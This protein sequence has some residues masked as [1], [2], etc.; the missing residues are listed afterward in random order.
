MDILATTQHRLAA[1]FI[2][3]RS[4]YELGLVIQN[5]LLCYRIHMKTR[6]RKHAW[7]VHRPT[8]GRPVNLACLLP[9]TLGTNRFKSKIQKS[10]CKSHK[11]Y[12]VASS[13][14]S[15][16]NKTTMRPSM[17]LLAALFFR[18]ASPQSMHIKNPV[19]PPVDVTD[20]CLNVKY[21]TRCM[22]TFKNYAVH[23]NSCSPDW[24]Y[25]SSICKCVDPKESPERAC[26]SKAERYRL[27]ARIAQVETN[28]ARMGR[29]ATNC[30]LLN[31]KQVEP[32]TGLLLYPLPKLYQMEAMGCGS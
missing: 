16:S 3:R 6:R 2:P 20:P 10:C 19:M 8:T 9:G 11:N 17:W 25:S 21:V 12:K 18:E 23:K 22:F 14:R 30:S 29:S 5:W 24:V 15:E 1:N 13:H 32:R 27:V 28:R 31:V 26:L 7:L 4:L